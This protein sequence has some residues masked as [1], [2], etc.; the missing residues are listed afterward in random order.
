MANFNLAL[1]TG[2]GSAI[3][4]SFGRHGLDGIDFIQGYSTGGNWPAGHSGY[5][6]IGFGRDGFH[7]GGGS[8]TWGPGGSSRQDWRQSAL[9]Y[10]GSESSYNNWTGNYRNHSYASDVFGDYADSRSGGNVYSG[11]Y[12]GREVRGNSWDGD[13]QSRQ[14][15]GNSHTGGYEY[16]GDYGNNYYRGSIPPYGRDRYCH[17]GGPQVDVFFG[18]NRGFDGGFDRGWGG[19]GHHHHHHHHGGHYGGHHGGHHGW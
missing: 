15:A 5:T 18:M 17:G 8:S 16:G 12:G 2:N 10:Q 7:V 13:W 1:G 6:D 11:N 3:D 14:Y 4:L 9:G 19:G